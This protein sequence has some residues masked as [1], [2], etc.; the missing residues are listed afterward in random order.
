MSVLKTKAYDP[1]RTSC[2]HFVHSGRS[3]LLFPLLGECGT[4]S[5]LKG[6]MIAYFVTA[7][8]GWVYLVLARWRICNRPTDEVSECAELG[9]GHIRITRAKSK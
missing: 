7:F 6:P 9:L 5:K 1:R 2:N 8:M 3:D 4:L